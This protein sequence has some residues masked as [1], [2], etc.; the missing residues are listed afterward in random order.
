MNL[1]DR[2]FSILRPVACFALAMLSAYPASAQFQR[3]GG[4]PFRPP[5]AT[6]HYAR[7]RDY[8]VR[9]LRLVFNIDGEHRSAHG[10]VTHTLAPL[11]S[12]L[13]SI[14]MDAGA[15][16]KILSCRID[17][18]DRPFTHDKDTL[19]ITPATA[20][21]RGKEVTVE[22]TYDMPGATRTGGANGAGGFSW[23]I[24]NPNDPERR[25]E[26]WTQGETDGNHRWVPCYDYPN[27]KCTSETIVT[28]PETWEVI[29]NGTEGPVT[30]DAAK[31]TR[32]FHWTMTQ[33]HSTYLLS[34]VGGEL[35]VR[36]AAW[37]GK[38]L[39]YVVPKGKA[40]LIPGSFGNTPDML[41]FFSDTVGVKYPWPKYAQDAMYD[42]GGGMENVSA[43]TLGQGSLTDE[44]SGHYAMS[45]LTSHE[46]AHQWFGDYVTCKDWGD[47][48]LNESFATFF[49]MIYTE[50]LDGK[51]AYDEDRESNL[52]Q[53]LFEAQRYQR[54]V[55]T[56]LY[57]NPDVMF[58]AHTYPKGGL[59][60][61]MLRRELGDAD[62]FR[63]LGHYL[64]VNALQ[65]VDTHDLEKA[66]TEE[67][68]H[69]VE[70]FFDQWI[71]K[72][73]HPVLDPTWTYDDTG[74]AIVLHV[75]QT[76][77]TA[78]GTPIY[79]LPLTIGILH[80]TAGSAAER[81]VVTLNQA[82][83]EFRIPASIKPDAVLIDPDHDLLK[84]VKDP[85]WSDTE[86]PVIMRNA[87][88]V[89]D[90]VAAIRR[91]ANMPQSFGFRR[92]NSDQAPSAAATPLDDA[93]IQMVT[94]ALRAE[95]SEQA[96]ALLIE[97]LGNA[98]KETLRPLLREQ[99]R[100]KQPGR[101]AAAL[102]ALGKL[103]RNDED[104]T[105]LRAAAKSDTEPYQVVNAALRA[106]GALDLNGS[107]DIFT[108]QAGVKSLN[109]QLARTV[110]SVVSDAKADAAVPILLKATGPTH[111][112][113]TRTSAVRALNSIAPNSPE[114][115][116]TLV[117]LLT[118]TSPP[119]LQQQ[120]VRTLRERG[121]KDALSTLRDLAAKA[122]DSDVRSAAKDA[123]EALDT[124]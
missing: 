117:A 2:C 82:E 42:F 111:N 80:N 72:P 96:G 118:P 100:S 25:T 85:H 94:D 54:P 5:Q 22:I 48:W 52:R 21:A 37:S 38:T 102:S 109:D 93:K 44:R 78:N 62:F 97:A 8:H 13:A 27:D 46:L 77:D 99:A 103:P 51:D 107:L 58:D 68:G 70:A 64:K 19:T 50:H 60:L 24:P 116:T 43:T 106:L 69:N 40:N 79:T 123:V 90:R 26:F 7:D 28:V 15:N 3:M 20:L 83:Q 124:K 73:G 33:P 95:S 122:T 17:G 71:F 11:R 67:T 121:D 105:L 88:C 101:R 9:H 34:L 89:I 114:V 1:S 29:G 6:M 108:H 61:H 112:T 92:R 14:V 31:H 63:G 91:Y 66:I 16:L 75:K 86:L 12:A 104:L 36:K 18:A 4:N 59:I 47:V 98:K 110:V 39:Y 81:Q 115:H 84:E 65:P 32:T 87:P 45:S 74:K 23:I 57:V 119:S 30:R 53:Y 120:V 113:F 76:Q 56:K 35:D 41:Q 55:S 49:Q 10:V